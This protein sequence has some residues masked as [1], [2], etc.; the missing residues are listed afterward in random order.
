MKRLNGQTLL[1]LLIATAVIGSGLFAATTIVFSNL[2]LSDRDADEVVAV[3]LAREAIEQAKQLRDSNWLAGVPFDTGMV[4]ALDDYSATPF[5]DGAPGVN[6]IS[7]DFAANDVSVETA[8]VRISQDPDTPG[9][10]T[11]ADRGAPETPWR[12]IVIFH[13]ICDAL[14]GFTYKED[15]QTCGADQK[16]GVRV[17]ARVQWQRKGKTFNRT[18]YEDL[19]DWR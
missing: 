1:E 11:Q 2:Q 16:V 3:N 14:G 6:E 4:N 19:F 12:R 10:Y 18:M 5:W 13:P 7:F 9:F 15:G 17:E 8:K